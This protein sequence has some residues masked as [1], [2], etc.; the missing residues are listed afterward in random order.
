MRYKCTVIKIHHTDQAG[1]LNDKLVYDGS[2]Q[3]EGEHEVDCQ[4]IEAVNENLKNEILVG[5]YICD[6]HAERVGDI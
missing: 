6:M 3:N 5:N 1:F 2:C 4:D